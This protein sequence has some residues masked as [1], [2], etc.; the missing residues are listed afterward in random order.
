MTDILPPLHY[1]LN[2]EDALAYERLPRAASRIEQI[3]FWIWLALAGL[4]AVALPPELVGATS[5]LRFWITALGLVVIQ[6]TIFMLVRAGWRRSRARGRIPQPTT[7]ELELEP[8]Q[9][10]VVENGKRREIPFEAIGALLPARNYLFMAAGSELVII[11]AAAFP[12]HGMDAMVETINAHMVAH[13]A[14]LDGQPVVLDDGHDEHHHG[15]HHPA[16]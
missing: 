9:V 6:Y 8:G 12:P 2:W 5:S 10:L 15:H 14:A 4:I 11:P 7:V 16:P 13:Y 3:A 1:T